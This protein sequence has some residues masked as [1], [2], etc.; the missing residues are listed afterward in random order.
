MLLISSMA[1]PLP[2]KRRESAIS[3]RQ[4]RNRLLLISG[5]GFSW[6]NRS[7]GRLAQDWM[8]VIAG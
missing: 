6:Q 3:N 5:D 1:N 2:S 8:L 4:R 7:F